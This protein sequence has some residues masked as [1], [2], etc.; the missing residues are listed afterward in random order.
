MNVNQNVMHL[1]MTSIVTLDRM[2][3]TFNVFMFVLI[4]CFTCVCD[5]V[6][7]A[8]QQNQ[9]TDDLYPAIM[10]RISCYPPKCSRSKG[11]FYH[12]RYNPAADLLQVGLG[13]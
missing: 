6:C 2:L 3:E 8:K 4:V 5:C 7:E 9:T 12:N 1:H 13:T 11:Q 10:R